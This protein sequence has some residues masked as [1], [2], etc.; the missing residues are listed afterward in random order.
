M[1][2]LALTIAALL[3]SAIPAGADDETGPGGAFTCD[4]GISTDVGPLDVAPTIERDRMYMAERPG[5]V[6]KHVPLVLDPEQGGLLSGGRYLFDT[7]ADAREY[8]RWVT[9]DFVLDGTLFLERSAFIDPDCHAW[10]VVGTA[11][12]GDV[13]DAQVALRTERWLMPDTD[14]A[15]TLAAQWPGIAAD[16]KARGLSAVWLLHQPEER[17]VSIVSFA[18]RASPLQPDLSLALLKTAP[19]LGPAFDAAGWTRTLDRTQWSLTIWFPYEHADSGEASLWPNSPPLPAPSP[20]DGV[21]EP[22]RGETHASAPIDCTPTCG[23]G[24]ADADETSRRC[25]SDVRYAW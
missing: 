9:E 6:F 2:R 15:D 7:E 20:V 25:P 5:M 19:T 11:L 18:P 13:R 12:W 23:D 21:C 22:S 1:L 10:R 4:F 16:A 17:L 14:Q 3:V 24:R 8:L